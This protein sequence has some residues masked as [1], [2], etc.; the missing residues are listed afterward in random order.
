M[1]GKNIVTINGRSYDAITGMPVVG[2]SSHTPKPKPAQD[3]PKTHRAFSDIAAPKQTHT[4]QHVKAH[5]VHTQLQ[6]SQTLYRAALKK[7]ILASQLQPARV[8]VD[9]DHVAGLPAK[10]SAHTPE[11]HDRIQKPAISRFGPDFKKAD[12]IPA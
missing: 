1:A 4:E 10:A 8:K 9:A 5:A 11:Y 2:S 7:P 3:S 6:K 12:S